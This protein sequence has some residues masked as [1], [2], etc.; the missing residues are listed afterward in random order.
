MAKHNLLDTDTVNLNDIFGNG[1]RY[2]V[3]VYQR[4]Y[5]WKEE[6]WQ[7]LWLD[8][9]SVSKEE[10][11]H[12]MGAIVLEDRKDKSYA[13]IDGQQRLVT[14]SIVALAIIKRLQDL[15]DKKVKE[16]ANEERKALLMN[17]YVGSKDAV[18]LHYSSKLFLNENNDAFYQSYLLRLRK[19]PNPHRLSVSEKMLWDAFDYFYQRIKEHFGEN[20]SGE[21]LADF[22]LNRMA[23]RLLFIQIVVEDELNA[24]TVFETLN[25]R[26][27]DLTVTD[28]LK[29]YLF[30]LS[31][32]SKT[33]QELAKEQWNRIID[34]T[35]LDDFPVFLRYYWNSRHEVVRKTNLFKVLRHEIKTASQAD[36]LLGELE[37]IAGIYA[38]LENPND[39]LWEGNKEIAKGVRELQL[40]KVTQ[41]YPLLLIAYERLREEFE[42]I[43]RICTV[44]SFRYNVIADFNTNL[45]EG[46][47]SRTALKIYE[48][49][50]ST[51]AQVVAE[52]KE[53]YPNDEV[54]TNAFSAKVISTKRNK[55]LAR[56]ILYSLEKQIS[57][58]DRD[59]EIDDGSIEHILPENPVEKW[60]Q[61]FSLEEQQ[62]YTYRLG[63]YTL[64]E[65]KKNSTECR[66]ALYG[67]KL[68]VYKT[69]QF[70]MT[71][72]IDFPEWT[73][74]QLKER[75]NR[76]AK[77][78]T[79]IWK[80]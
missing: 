27:I 66:D 20:V 76:L 77:Y 62:N 68:P 14:L 17:T 28:L 23:E 70:G 9:L 21:D 55:K 80:I 1:K 48:G 10:A 53:I 56:Y 60:K 6:H 29:N 49:K 79:S 24:Y 64:L 30:S 7:D 8:I 15:I 5:S 32:K 57:G 13:I 25:A 38:A 44:I 2:R 46:Y 63:N 73:V 59:F 26:G 78:A 74:K 19:P 36:E 69:S 33:D 51:S 61:F 22:I 37:A 50:I 40:F 43:L 11:T 65:K 34:I 31:S 47:Y 3:P 52:L 16:E 58:I 4:D 39:E 72:S 75:Q 12:Y 71:K 45:L 67:E 41:C 54:F 18:S 35:D 42:R